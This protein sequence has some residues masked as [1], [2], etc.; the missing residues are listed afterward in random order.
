VTSSRRPIW[1][2]GNLWFYFLSST[3]P[4]LCVRCAIDTFDPGIAVTI[5]NEFALTLY[6]CPSNIRRVSLVMGTVVSR[7]LISPGAM[8]RVRLAIV[9]LNRNSDDP[10]NNSFRSEFDTGEGLGICRGYSRNGTG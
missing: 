3:A 6:S 2:T 5:A 10:A 9:F 1:I 7:A 8:L 4:R